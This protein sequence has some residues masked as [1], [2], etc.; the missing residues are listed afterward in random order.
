MLEFT[1]G[2]GEMFEPAELAWNIVMCVPSADFSW[3]WDVKAALV[4]AEAHKKWNHLAQ[5]LS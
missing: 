1:M 2:M 4:Y 3:W 5:A